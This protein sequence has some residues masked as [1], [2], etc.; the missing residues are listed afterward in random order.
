MARK[1][2][3]TTNTY[4]YFA[5]DQAAAYKNYGG[6]GELLLGATRG[7]TSFAIEQDI[8]EMEV[9]GAK[10][11]VK[12]SKRI[13]AVRAIITANFIQLNP[14]LFQLALPGSGV[15]DYPAAPETKTHDSV[16]RALQ[17]ALTDY[18]TNIALVGECSGSSTG[19]IECIV[20]NA[21]VNDNLEMVFNPNDETVLA[22]K[23]V[24]HFDP[25]DLDTEPW[26]IRFPVIS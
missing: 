22:I 5:L 4:K 9:D 20:S 24:G 8:R 21:L 14:G 23:W 10:G 19:Y 25:S 1:H 12:G 6:P 18:C 15:A 16:T 7:G 3:I 13:I 11:P 26:E 2:G 17:I